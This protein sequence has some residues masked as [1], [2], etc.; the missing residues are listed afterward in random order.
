MP[1]IT[2]TK[3]ML[4]VINLRKK[5]GTFL[6]DLFFK[7]TKT[8][9][10]GTMVLDVKSG[11]RVMA[12]FVSPR[13]G[14]RILE[15]EGFT[16]REINVPKIAPERLTT[17]DDVSATGM[18]ENEFSTKTPKQRQQAI[19]VTDLS[20]LDDSIIR[21]EEWMAREVI[22]NKHVTIKGE[23]VEKD[24]KFDTD[25]KLVLSGAS[26]WNDEASDPLATI[27]AEQSKITKATGIKPKVMVL[28]SDAADAF[29]SH[30]KVKEAFN[31][32]NIVLGELKPSIKDDNVTFV[33]KITALGLEIYIYEEW[34]V[35]DEGDEQP[36]LPSG[37]AILASKD[38]G[39]MHYGAVK[40]MEKGNFVLIE[41]KRVPKYIVDE[42][43]ETTKLRLSSKPLPTPNDTKSW[44]VLT[45]L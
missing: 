35:D 39:V 1:R 14:G 21:R 40:Q 34:F 10:A 3:V 25:D 11:K 32:R 27:K 15:R 8:H 44:R 45:V 26:L 33:G 22:L 7:K 9:K 38:L 2:D 4:A 18:G 20:E 23:G 5:P 28:D 13:V 37:T 42:D 17:V 24:V 36:Y 31:N 6:K 43:N 19:L 16:T 12:P 41:E 29:L 30:A